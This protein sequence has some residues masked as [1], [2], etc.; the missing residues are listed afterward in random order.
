MMYQQYFAVSLSYSGPWHTT[1]TSQFKY[2]YVS[3]FVVVAILLKKNKIILYNIKKGRNKKAGHRGAVHARN[4]TGCLNPS[5][6]TNC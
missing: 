4:T 3:L 6:L 1:N 2:I 5:T